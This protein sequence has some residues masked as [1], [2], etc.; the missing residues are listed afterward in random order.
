MVDGRDVAAQMISHG[1]AVV[2]DNGKADYSAV[3][4]RAKSN[5]SGIWASEFD[6]PVEYR[7]AHP[8]EPDAAKVTDS[9]RWTSPRRPQAQ[10]SGYPYRSCAQARAADAAPMYRGQP[11]YNPNLDGDGDGI[12]CEPYRGRR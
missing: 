10:G 6:M 1:L 8:R 9:R 7:R 3:E 11:G 2:L 4:D 5:K 12:S